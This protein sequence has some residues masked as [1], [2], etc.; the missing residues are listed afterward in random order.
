MNHYNDLVSNTHGLNCG[1]DQDG[2]KSQSYQAANIPNL[3]D[4]TSKCNACGNSTRCV[5]FVDMIEENKCYFVSSLDHTPVVISDVV[6]IRKKYFNKVKTYEACDEGKFSLP[7]ADYNVA[8]SCQVC[9]EGKYQSWETMG[10]RCQACQPGKISNLEDGALEKCDDCP[11]GKYPN[12]PHTQC[13]DC[14]V[15]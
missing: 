9:D 1:G 3:V 8:G 10:E 14:P 11:A 4:C 7:E 5:G 12:G 6:D 13:Q 15:T 2:G